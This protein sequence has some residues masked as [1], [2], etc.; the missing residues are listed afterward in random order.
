MFPFRHD[1]ERFQ[2]VADQIKG[3]LHLA[4]PQAPANMVNNIRKTGAF[5][6]IFGGGVR[7]ALDRLGDVLNT[8]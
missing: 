6:A 8:H 1:V 2:G 5:L 3:S 4:V 7:P